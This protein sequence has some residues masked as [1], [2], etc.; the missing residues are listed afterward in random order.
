MSKPS[1]AIDLTV[2]YEDA[3]AGRLTATIAVVPGT[4]STGRTEGEARGNV[5]ML[6]VEPENIPDRNGGARP[7]HSGGRT[8]SDARLGSRLLALRTGRL[9][10][11]MAASALDSLARRSRRF[12]RRRRIRGSVPFR[13]PQ[14]P[15]CP[16][17]QSNPE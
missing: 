3:G 14:P 17:C 11:V 7:H 9:R 13:V 4:I 1:D 5:A 6:S 2:V 12:R 8:P 10:S 16:C 15:K